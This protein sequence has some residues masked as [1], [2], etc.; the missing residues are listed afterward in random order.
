MPLCFRIRNCSFTYF[1]L[2]KVRNFGGHSRNESSYMKKRSRATGD[3]EALPEFRAHQR[4][5]RFLDSKLRGG[6]D[7]AWVKVPDPP[8]GGYIHEMDSTQIVKAVDASLMTFCLHVEA[9][10]ASMIGEG[11]YTIGPCGEET[12]SPAGL[13]LQEDDSLALHYRHVAINLCRQ[14]STDQAS[15]QEIIL[16]RARGYTVSRHDAVTGGVHCSIGSSSGHDYVVTSTLAS[17]CPSAVG[18]ALG[19]ALCKSPLASSRRISMVTVGD[20]SVHNHHFWSAFHLARHSRHR[21]IRCPV[22]FGVSDNGLSISYK[23][24]GYVDTLWKNDPIVPLFTVNG[25]DFLH[26][27]SQTMEAAKYSRTFSAPSVIL[28]SGLVRRFGHAA[29]DRQ[30]AY[31]D[32]KTIDQMNDSSVLE[33]MIAQA[34]EVHSVAS[35]SEIRDRLIEITK[36]TENSFSVASAEPKVTHE[37]MLGRV[38]APIATYRSVTS[39]KQPLLSTSSA[40]VVQKPDVMRKHMNRVIAES[41]EKDKC[42]AYLGEDV[43]HGGYYAVTEGIAAHFPGRVIDFPPDETSLLGAAMGFS[44]LGLLPIVEIPYAKY[45]DCGA[46]MFQEIAVTYWLSAGKCPVG[47]IIRLQGFGAGVFG[48]NFHTS[49]VLTIPPGI[50]VCCYSNG[51]DYVKGFRNAIR[52]AKVGRVVMFVDC[53]NLLNLRHLHDKDRAWETPYPLEEE[54][55]CDFDFNTIRQY[56]S[57]AKWAVVTYGSGVVTSL[58][59]RRLLATKMVLRS[60]S[61]LDII[62]CCFLSDI[63]NGLRAVIGGYKGVVFADICKQGPG[64]ILSSLSCSL[65][66]AGLLPDVWELISSPRTYN[67]LG[68]VVTFLSAEDVAKTVETMMKSRHPLVRR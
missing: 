38:S 46:D 1:D 27:Y 3:Y 14:L 43:I 25:N 59:A 44:Q 10:I 9:R 55:T 29:T 13:C 12:L 17:Q 54:S 6:E 15:I 24:N 45:L 47:M 30:V 5:Q 18:R 50:D 26:V 60:E 35:Y 11:F 32:S 65:R 4:L 42:V 53:T 20:G 2:R 40:E 37:D 63:P 22:V 58:Q 49:N 28:Y 31:L 21:K 48:G 51:H 57:T 33:S 41:M 56:G 64:S 66:T 67:P 23:T 34:V 16:N 39:L 36:Y 68:S 7:Y 52:Q 62:D 8:K 19:Y 61:E